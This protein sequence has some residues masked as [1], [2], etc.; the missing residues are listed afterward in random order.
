MSIWQRLVGKKAFELPPDSP[1]PQPQPK[2]IGVAFGGGGMKGTAHIGVLK[3]LAEYGVPIHMVAGTSIGSAVA[4]L[5]AS[6]Y[7][8]KMMQRVFLEFDIDSLIKVRPSRMGLIPAPGYTE[9]VRAC[10]KNRRIEDMDIPLKIVAVDL[11]SRKKI[12][13]D[14]GDTALAVR[15]SSAVPG[16]FTPVQM[17]EMMLVDG[18]VLD[19]CPGG[20]VRDMGADVVIAVSLHTPDTSKPA[21]MLEIVNRSLDIA[22]V[23]YQQID[24]DLVLRP[25]TEHRSFLDREALGACLALGEEC[26]RRH[27]EEI[28]A[29]TKG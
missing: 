16:V 13:F 29:L 19:N 8:W 25:V 2:K 9:V 7:D 24:A 23:S 22:A 11:V 1:P 21:N 27:I 20:V 3:V 6:G 10:T 12:V 15:A 17:G 5:Y 18:Y 26:A 4:A 28:I 14:R